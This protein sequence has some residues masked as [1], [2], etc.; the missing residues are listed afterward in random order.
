MSILREALGGGVSLRGGV[1]VKGLS[2]A[3]ESLLEETSKAILRILL[4]TMDRWKQAAGFVQGNSYRQ[5]DSP[6]K[7]RIIR[8]VSKKVSM[9][10]SLGALQGCLKNPSHLIFSNGLL[11]ATW[12]DSEIDGR[13]LLTHS[14]THSKEVHPSTVCNRGSWKPSKCHQL[15]VH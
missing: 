15:G 13:Q 8:L 2:S 4:R 1:A 6:L 12:V 10:L 9:V 3:S 11:L 14:K 5:F 7:N